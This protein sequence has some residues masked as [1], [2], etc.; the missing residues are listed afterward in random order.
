LVEQL[1]LSLE[2]CYVS[3]LGD[4]RNTIEKFR[5]A[6]DFYSVAKL[7]EIHQDEITH[8]ATGQKWFAWAC[9]V[10]QTDRY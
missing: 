2:V 5:N 10:L 6:N 4:D 3:G 7:E 8:V 9:E 1:S